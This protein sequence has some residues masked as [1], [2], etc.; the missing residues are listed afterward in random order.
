MQERKEYLRY[1]VWLYEHAPENLRCNRIRKGYS[2]SPNKDYMEILACRECKQPFTREVPWQRRC[3]N[4]IK[5]ELL[6]GGPTN[7]EYKVTSIEEV[8]KGETLFVADP[9]VTKSAG[10]AGKRAIHVARSSSKTCRKCGGSL[11]E[12]TYGCSGCYSYKESSLAITD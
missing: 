7:N 6:E 4:C 9:P 1:R 11:F 5:S 3:D 10:D 12:P 2:E 8:F